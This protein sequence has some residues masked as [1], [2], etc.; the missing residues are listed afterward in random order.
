MPFISV[1]LKQV[2]ASNIL[3]TSSKYI[4]R[5]FWAALET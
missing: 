1:S 5:N 2:S 4:L 3:N